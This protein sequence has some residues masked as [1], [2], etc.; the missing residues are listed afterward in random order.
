MEI[1]MSAIAKI[2]IWKTRSVLLLVSLLVLGTFAVRAYSMPQPIVEAA[3]GY[4]QQA[5]AALE[6][7]EHNKGGFRVKAIG[8]VGQ[9]LGAVRKAF[10][11]GD[12]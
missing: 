12:R 3:L 1:T 4:L 10:A 9:A 11:A 7:A 8:H 5:K 6:R 2:K